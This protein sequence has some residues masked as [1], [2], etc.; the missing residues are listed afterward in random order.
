MLISKQEC[1]DLERALRLEWLELNGCGVFASGTVAGSNTGR[2]HALLV[3]T[4]APEHH[5][6]VLVNHVE[7]WLRVAGQEI[8]LS[9]N[10]YPGVMRPQ[11]YR[12]CFSFAST[13]WPT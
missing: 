7:E 8:S 6:Y 10:M 1:H 4:H 9:T 11:E 12:H 13:P 2:Y 3:V 5:R